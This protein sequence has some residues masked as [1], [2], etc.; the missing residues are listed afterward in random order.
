MPKT[1]LELTEEEIRSYKITPPEWHTEERRKK[2]LVIANSIA[3]TLREDF[4]AKRVVAFGSIVEKERFSPWSDIDIAVYGIQSNLFYKAV[5]ASIDISQDFH[6]DI[7]DPED[8]SPSLR[9]S[10][11]K[12][13]IEI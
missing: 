8:C 4:G 12:Y 13:G 11:E 9:R 2:A 10:I 5:S 7:V 3:R 6:V 1:A